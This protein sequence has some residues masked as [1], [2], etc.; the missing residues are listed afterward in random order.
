MGYTIHLF[1]WTNNHNI[2]YLDLPEQR[3]QV[4]VGFYDY[5]CFDVDG[6]NMTKKKKK[7]IAIRAIKFI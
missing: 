1:W 7:T 2:K 3:T 6:D 5:G 4:T